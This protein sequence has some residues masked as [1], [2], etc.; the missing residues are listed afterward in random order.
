MV[1][2]FADDSHDL[3]GGFLQHLLH[4]LADFGPV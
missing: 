1:L 3:E 2:V 4:G